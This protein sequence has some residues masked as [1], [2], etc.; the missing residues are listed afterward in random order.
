M[1]PLFGHPWS[2]L[3]VPQLLCT[4]PRNL[5]FREA[6]NAT[7]GSYLC[8]PPQAERTHF[9]ECL[10]PGDACALRAAH[11]RRKD[12]DDTNDTR[13]RHYQPTM[14]V[15]PGLTPEGRPRRREET[16]RPSFVT[17]RP[18]SLSFVTD[19][20]CQS[21]HCFFSVRE[22]NKQAGDG[23]PHRMLFGAA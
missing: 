9:E 20:G 14:D 13:Y 10:L 17:S 23:L 21:N 11:L 19:I 2:S 8:P 5:R 18:E 15:A 22:V 7:I 1:S 6:G 3:S 16:T 4:P 12:G